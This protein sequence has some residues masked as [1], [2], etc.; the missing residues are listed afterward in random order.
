[1][2]IYNAHGLVKNVGHAGAASPSASSDEIFHLFRSK[3]RAAILSFMTIGQH[4]F[5]FVP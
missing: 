5:A 4:I 1:M 3:R 2:I